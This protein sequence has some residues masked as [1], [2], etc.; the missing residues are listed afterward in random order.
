MISSLGISAL[1]PNTTYRS[2]LK[3]KL[4]GLCAVKYPQGHPVYIRKNT[5]SISEVGEPL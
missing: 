1:A 4:V 2:N 5:Y 3:R